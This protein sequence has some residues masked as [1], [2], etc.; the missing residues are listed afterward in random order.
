MNTSDDDF[1]EARVVRPYTVTGGRT[2]VGK[3]LD[4]PFEALVRRTTAAAHPKVVLEHR[5]ILDLCADHLLSVAELSAQLKLPLGITRV[6]ISDL[7]GAGLVTI[8]HTELT[9][10]STADQLKVLESVLNGISQL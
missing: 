1:T 6:L 7:A 2:R 5:R 4:L 8:H 10:T 3:R 9:K